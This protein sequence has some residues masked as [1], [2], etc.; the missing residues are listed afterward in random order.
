MCT[1]NPSLCIG[2]KSSTTTTDVWVRSQDLTCDITPTLPVKAI[3]TTWGVCARKVPDLPVGG[4]RED[5]S[6]G[7][8]L[9]VNNS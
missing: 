4:D 3:H 7:N 5:V 8:S 6:G 1:L 9:L 2:F